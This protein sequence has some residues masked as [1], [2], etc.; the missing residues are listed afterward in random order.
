MV[1]VVLEDLTHDLKAETISKERFLNNFKV[2]FTS[3]DMNQFFIGRQMDV[4]NKAYEESDSKDFRSVLKKVL[5][6]TQNDE[7]SVGLRNLVQTILKI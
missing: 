4:M 5:E 6:I 7:H 3:Y 2:I 1:E